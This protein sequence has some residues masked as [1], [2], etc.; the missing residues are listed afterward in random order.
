MSCK[1]S[2]EQIRDFWTKQA[3]VHGTA[4][5]ASWSDVSV[6]HMEIKNILQYIEDGDH[7]IDV[8]CANGYSTI[9]FASQKKVKIKGVDYIPEMVDQAK[10]RLT[11]FKDR[12]QGE[13]EFG[14]DD[15]MHL[16]QPANTFDKV[17]LIRVIINLSNWENQLIGLQNCARIVKPG[18][19]LLVSEATIQGWQNLNN[20]RKE[21]GLTEIPMPSFNNYLDQEKVIDALTPALKLVD[22]KNYASTYFV[23]TRIFKPLLNEALGNRINTA[24]PNMEWN[25]FWSMAPSWGDY[26]TQKLFIFQKPSLKGVAI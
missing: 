17:V 8:G 15:V 26:G 4:P 20:L 3:N 22:V 7:V 14:V 5:Q 19:L 23:A 24:D 11:E 16:N 12:L 9:Q 10:K 25:R 18:G 21:W 6:I 1:Y 2:L 13:I